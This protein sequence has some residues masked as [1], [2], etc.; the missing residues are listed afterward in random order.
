MT[1]AGI[2]FPIGTSEHPAVPQGVQLTCTFMCLGNKLIHFMTSSA[3]SMP[4]ELK[5]FTFLTCSQICVIAV[6]NW[7]CIFHLMR[8]SLLGMI[9]TWH[10]FIV[11]AENSLILKTCLLFFFFFKLNFLTDMAH[12]KHNFKWILH[13]SPCCTKTLLQITHTHINTFL[14]LFS[15]CLSIMKLQACFSVTSGAKYNPGKT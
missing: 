11:M 1:G 6:S 7:V 4:R 14:R 5:P 12:V 9:H 15:L 3:F 13:N 10:M 2:S 8:M